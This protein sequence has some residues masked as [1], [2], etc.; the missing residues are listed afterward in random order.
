MISRNCK[1]LIAAKIKEFLDQ[2]PEYSYW[3]VMFSALRY[4]F[5]GEDISKKGLQELTDEDIYKS[6]CDALRQEIK[7]ENNIKH[8]ISDE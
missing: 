6:L 7:I 4:K 5:K 1:P 2:F 3:D 8:K